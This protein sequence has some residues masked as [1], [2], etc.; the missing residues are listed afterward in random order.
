MKVEGRCYII[1]LIECVVSGDLLERFWD[2]WKKKYNYF[3]L[4]DMLKI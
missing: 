1:R 4:I 3:K 2:A